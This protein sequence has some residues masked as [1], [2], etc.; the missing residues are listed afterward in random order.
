MGSSAIGVRGAIPLR[1]RTGMAR[2]SSRNTVGRFDETRIHHDRPGVLRDDRVR[3]AA[4]DLSADA[5]QGPGDRQAHRRRVLRAHGRL[6]LGVHGHARGH[7]PGRADRHR[8]RD[9]AERGARDA[10]QGAGEVRHL[11]PSSLGPRI[12]RVGVRR[13]GAHHRPRGDGEA[14]GDAA[15]RHA[16]AAERPHAGRQ[17]QRPHR[18][19][20]R[21]RG[22]SRPSSRSTMPTATAC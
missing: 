20:P 10:I 14:A 19:E 12:R 7:R 22:T 4:R 21:R 9:V 5:V 2:G 18:S 15:R 17:R 6:P 8:V 3:A 16:A 1:R 13:H 11:Q